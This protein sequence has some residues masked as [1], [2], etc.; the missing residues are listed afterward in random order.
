MPRPMNGD[1]LLTAPERNHYFY[2][3]LLS[4]AELEMESRYV[5]QKRWL[6]NRLALGS[7]VVCGLGVVGDPQ[8]AQR[9]RVE[10]GL[11]IDGRG[12]EIVVPEPVSVDPRRLTDGD[13]LP[14][15]ETIQSGDVV[16]CLA[17]AE[18]CTDLV[19][20]LVPDC[21]D[22]G[23][24]APNVI[25]EGFRVVV[26]RADGPAPEAPACTLGALPLPPGAA[27]H[28]LLADRVSGPCAEPPAVACVPLARVALGSAGT[29][30]AIDA[31]AGRRL[32]YGNALLHQ[33]VLC[34]AERVGPLA[35]ARVLRYVA[36]DGQTGEPDQALGAPLRV[37][38]LDG[39][40]DPVAGVTVLFDV[41]SGGGTVDPATA[42]TDAQGRVQTEWTLG[43]QQGEQRVTAG[44]VGALFTVSFTAAA[45]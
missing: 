19:P 31:R 6:L 16:V 38:V 21:D 34:L 8:D 24:C 17:Y 20:V 32:V 7:G 10:T 35:G 41:A 13:G 25:R 26:R 15:G 40:G 12:R 27:L 14:T 30:P 39:A 5:N 2:G 28:A 3:K 11:A 18:A 29:T 4:V 33:L 42:S 45:A 23:D 44:A 36:G 43:P 22:G 37:E 1:G 9:L